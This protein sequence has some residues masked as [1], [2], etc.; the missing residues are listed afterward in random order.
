MTVD[1]GFSL[2]G[3]VSGLLNSESSTELASAIRDVLAFAQESHRYVLTINISH[4]P[5]RA[6]DD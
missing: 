1:K 3:L 5:K 2:I 6:D 4:N